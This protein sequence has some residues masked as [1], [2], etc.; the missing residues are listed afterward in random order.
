L[1]RGLKSNGVVMD[2]NSGQ[3]GLSAARAAWSKGRRVEN[4]SLAAGKRVATG[5][6]EVELSGGESCLPRVGDLPIRAVPI[7]PAHLSMAAARKIA[8]LKRA[9]VLFVER[10]GRLMGTLDEHALVEAPDEADVADCLRSIELCLGP[11]TTVERAQEL[12]VRSRT[13]ALPVAAGVFLLGAVSRADVERALRSRRAPKRPA[14]TAI[15][16]ATA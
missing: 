12:F 5:V 7:I 11:T 14:R 2:E 8:E 16:R 10:G 13:T 1:A 4:G 9:T 6:G 3:T 15:A